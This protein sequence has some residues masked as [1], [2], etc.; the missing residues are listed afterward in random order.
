MSP[1]GENFIDQTF[2][3]GIEVTLSLTI[4]ERISIAWL[5][6]KKSTNFWSQIRI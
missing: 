1:I 5:N 6:Q 4:T 3:V 2:P